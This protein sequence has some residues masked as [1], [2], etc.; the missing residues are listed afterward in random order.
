VG[1]SA[2]FQPER[3]ELHHRVPRCLLTLREKADAAAL[4]GTGF[5]AWLDYEHEAIRWGVDPDVSRA[6]LAALVDSSLEAIPYEDHRGIHRVDFARWGRRGGIAT[7]ECGCGG[8]SLASALG[9]LRS[10][11]EVGHQPVH[12]AW[13]GRGAG[14]RHQLSRLASLCPFPKVPLRCRGPKIPDD[15][16]SS[17][18]TSVA[19]NCEGAPWFS[20]R[21]QG[22]PVRRPAQKRET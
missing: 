4:D 18:T 13:R 7:L 8:A 5:Q 20:S 9:P 14:V 10:G 16:R 22:R 3:V 17:P 2:A 1:T 15:E 12:L 6:E 19:P 11:A 21:A